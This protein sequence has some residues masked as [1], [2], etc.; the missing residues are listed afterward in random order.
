MFGLFEEASMNL[1]ETLSLDS[2]IDNLESQIDYFNQYEEALNQLSNLGVDNSIIE[3]LDP[4]QAVAFA[5]ELGNM[6]TSAAAEKVEELNKSFEGLSD[7][8]DEVSKQMLA[9]NDELNQRF[10]DIQ[11]DME[12]AIDEMDLED[13]AAESAKSTLEGYIKQLKSSGDLAVTEAQNIAN[14]I[15]E[16]LSS[17]AQAPTL[18]VSLSLIHI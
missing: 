1:E 6:D 8:K 2:A 15:S 16:A 7:A 9:V 14:R 3:Q 4:E 13:E 5:Q 12:D 17:S 11:K 10:D 18:A